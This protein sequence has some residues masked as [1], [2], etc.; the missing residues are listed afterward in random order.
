MEVSFTPA[1]DSVNHVEYYEL[2]S[3]SG[4]VCQCPHC[5]SLF[6]GRIRFL[7]LG[8]NIPEESVSAGEVYFFLAGYVLI[9]DEASLVLELRPASAPDDYMDA[10]ERVAQR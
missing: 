8:T 9:Y 10:V 7:W 5:F 3:C 4:D 1:D 2:G 6:E